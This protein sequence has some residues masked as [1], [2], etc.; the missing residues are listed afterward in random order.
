M[1]VFEKE[2]YH[3]HRNNSHSDLWTVGSLINTPVEAYNYFYDGIITRAHTPVSVN[4]TQH[5]L[6]K[7]LGDNLD[8][9]NDFTSKP[10]ELA[11]VN[12]EYLLNIQEF[13]SHLVS[14]LDK[15]FDSLLYSRKALRETL[16]ENVRQASYSH[17]PSRQK[18]FWLSEL[19]DIT[20]W[21]N[22]FKDSKNKSIFK[23]IAT[24]DFFKA[25]GAHIQLDIFKLSDFIESA[26]LYWKGSPK[27]I[28]TELPEILF[29]GNLKVVS[30]YENPSQI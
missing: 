18:C 27:G 3:I 14:V 21:W 5:N 2:F 9:F 10:I 16:F 11:D 22:D 17:L 28:E 13:N 1:K 15:T 7:Y 24:G 19:S 12:D 8:R 20:T 26:D 29:E 4:L 6:I 25:D 23:V 30:I